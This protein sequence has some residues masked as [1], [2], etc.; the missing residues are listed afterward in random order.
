M[1]GM[2]DRAPEQGQVPKPVEGGPH[3]CLGNSERPGNPADTP[4]AP[5][6]HAPVYVLGVLVHSQFLEQLT[7]SRTARDVTNYSLSA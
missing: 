4:F 6:E 7:N 5:P 1:A 3:A 2:A